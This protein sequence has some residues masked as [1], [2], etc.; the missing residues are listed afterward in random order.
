M[1][2]T[3]IPKNTLFSSLT[4]LSISPDPGNALT[5]RATGLYVPTVKQVN[6]TILQAVNP[7]GSVIMFAG[8]INPPSGWLFCHGTELNRQEYQALFKVIGTTYGSSNNHTFKLPDYRNQFLR[9]NRAGRTLGNVEE[10]TLGNHIHGFGYSTGGND[11][12]FVKGTQDLP[13][14]DTLRYF[15]NPGEGGGNT[16]VIKDSGYAN[17]KNWIYKDGNGPLV[18]DIPMGKDNQELYPK[19][20]SVEYIIYTGVLK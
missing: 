4:Q 13:N 15:W 1:S 10:S 11:S 16:Y 12:Y 7:V 19:N 9:G 14:K 17:F 3:L 20:I 18:I 5:K 2:E 6:T 8:T